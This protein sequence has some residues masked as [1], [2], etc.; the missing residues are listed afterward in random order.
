MNSDCDMNVVQP[1]QYM[2]NACMPIRRRCNLWWPLSI[3]IVSVHLSQLARSFLDIQQPALSCVIGPI[4]WH[5]HVVRLH[6]GTHSKI[7]RMARRK[8]KQLNPNTKLNLNNQ[9]MTA[10]AQLN[11][12]QS[13][14]KT[15]LVEQQQQQKNLNKQTKITNNINIY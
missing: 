5:R 11:K 4:C 13:I 15:S 2:Q 12:I 10:A 9:N 8:I 14:N 6:N 7:Q 3:T 1:L